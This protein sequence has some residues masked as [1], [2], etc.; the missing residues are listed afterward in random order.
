[1]AAVFSIGAQISAYPPDNA[2]LIYYK[3]MV[4]FTRPDEVLWNQI[5]DAAKGDAEVTEEVQRY[6]LEDRS[7]LITAL[8]TASEISNCDWALD[9]SEG[10]SMEMSH[11]G[12]M[13]DFT[14]ILLAEA[15]TKKQQQRPQEA[16][17]ICLSTL[18]MAGHVGKDTFI[19]Y[20]V[21]V[22]MSGLTYDAIGD[23]LSAIPPDNDL[24][25][26]LRR[27]LKLPEYNVLE[28]KTPM[29]NESR[30]LSNE[31]LRIHD[32]KQEVIEKLYGSQGGEQT[33]PPLLLKR[34]PEFLRRCANYYRDFFDRNIKI[35]ELPYDAAIR[36]LDE[37]KDKPQKDFQAGQ[38]EAFPTLV[39]APAVARIYTLSIRHQTHRNALFTAID[40]YRIYAEQGSLPSELPGDCLFDLF[41]N[42]PFM[43]EVTADGFILRCHEKEQGKQQ[44][45]EYPFRIAK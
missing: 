40:L 17:D 8:R 27:E 18:R 19:S 11:L 10:L 7:Q 6:L 5:T 31:I 32:R 2:A 36:A 16:M 33:I 20:L 24:L 13:R 28:L 3:Y 39:L 9:Y 45:W 25:A 30:Y 41:S 12:A 21:G 42:R 29:L 14:Y 4:N 1:M 34:D 23:I 15:Q 22:A 44:P 38:Q 35:Q 43:Y 37:L 26:E